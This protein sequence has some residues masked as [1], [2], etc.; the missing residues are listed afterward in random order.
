MKILICIKNIRYSCGRHFLSKDRIV[1]VKNDTTRYI[2]RT[3]EDANN[4][5]SDATPL[6]RD[7]FKDYFRDATESEVQMFTK[8]IKTI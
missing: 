7:N 6:D 4:K 5:N 2:Y 8:G 1:A 3:A